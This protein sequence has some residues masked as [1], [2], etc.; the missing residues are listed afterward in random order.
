ML[1]E[2]GTELDTR[3]RVLCEIFN[4]GCAPSAPANQEKGRQRAKRVPISTRSLA[5]CGTYTKE[6]QAARRA[7]PRRWLFRCAYILVLVLVL[8]YSSVTKP[9][10]EGPRRSGGGGLRVSL[11]RCGSHARGFTLRLSCEFTGR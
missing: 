2:G 5:T 6:W 4:A 8:E 7:R 3:E 11:H 10:N 9:N 1:G